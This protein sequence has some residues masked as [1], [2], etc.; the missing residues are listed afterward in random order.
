MYLTVFF[1]SNKSN[2]MS[3]FFFYFLVL[4]LHLT[5]LQNPSSNSNL[6]EKFG[7]TPFFRKIFLSISKNDSSDDGSKE[8]QNN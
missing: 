3:S 2:R 1:C 4:G 7:E 8:Y 5:S 6:F